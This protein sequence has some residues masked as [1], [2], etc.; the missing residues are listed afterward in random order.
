MENI[1]LRYGRDTKGYTPE[2]IAAALGI[3]V[4]EYRKLETGRRMITAP[5][6]RKLEELFGIRGHYIYQAALQLDMLL[7][8]TETVLIQEETI[9]QLRKNRSAD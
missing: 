4:K 2:Y 6:V 7:A 1:I 9:R 5:Q 3:S 8:T